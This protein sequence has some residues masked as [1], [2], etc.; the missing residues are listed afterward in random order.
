MKKNQRIYMDILSSR[1]HDIQPWITE[2]KEICWL[3]WELWYDSYYKLHVEKYP[4]CEELYDEYLKIFNNKIDG[5]YGIWVVHNNSLIG[6]AIISDRSDF[7]ETTS[8]DVW[9]TDL[10]ILPKWRNKGYST[11]L[12]DC[13]ISH[14]CNTL[15]CLPDV[16][17]MYLKRGWIIKYSINEWIILHLSSR[18]LS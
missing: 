4:S 9:L 12:I 16:L 2:L 3:S 14:G 18:Y 6:T 5:T 10:F 17:P 13:A 15:S 8:N 7:D 1:T 11:M